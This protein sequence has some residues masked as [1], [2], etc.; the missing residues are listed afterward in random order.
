MDSQSS[1]LLHDHIHVAHFASMLIEI[2]LFGAGKSSIKNKCA[3]MKTHPHYFRTTLFLSVF[4][5]TS[6]DVSY[7]EHGGLKMMWQYVTQMTPYK[8]QK[9]AL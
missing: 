4:I 5:R 9:L 3:A 7:S 6:S 2:S 8:Q 1:G